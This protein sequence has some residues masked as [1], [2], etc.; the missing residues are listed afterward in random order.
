MNRLN[1][2][3]FFSLLLIC[4]GL[5]AQSS[6]DE[7]MPVRGLSIAAPRTQSVDQFVKFIDDELAAR[8]IN[9]LILR[10][11]YNYQY[12]SHPELRDS[13]ALSELDVKKIVMACRQNGIRIVPQINLL[14]HQSW[15]GSTGNL[16]KMYPEFDETPSVKMP[17]NYE[18]PNEDGLYCKSYCPLH[19]GVHK[20]VFEVMDE[21]LDVFEASDFHAGMDE[22]FYIGEEECPRCSGHDKAELFA[23]EV[24]R[25]RNHL[26]EKERNLWIWGDRLLDGKA[27]GLGM[28]EASMNNTYRAIDMIPKDVF[29]CDW[30]YE[31][32]DKTAVYFAMKGFKVATCPWRD[33]E[34][35]LVQVQDM[36]GFRNTATPEMKA[37]FQGIIL[38]YWSS[39]ENFIRNFYDSNVEGG[40]KEMLSIF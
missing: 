19:P 14:G 9:V 22:V 3:A 2:I 21:L 39:A 12:K 34:V 37:N 40:T 24:W 4:I 10:V 33:P 26:A 15:A 13:A 5:S 32:P 23:G 20:V 28:W 27:T 17:E 18:W 35:A 29:I 36:I 25:I 7:L 30:H 31:R 38:T 8:Q 1:S 6:N 16:L 11:D